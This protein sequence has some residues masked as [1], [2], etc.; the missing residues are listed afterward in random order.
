MKNIA[1]LSILVPV[2]LFNNVCYG[3]IKYKFGLAIQQD[4][5]F[6]TL[7]GNFHNNVQ[8]KKRDPLLS[9]F[10]IGLNYSF[11][12][13]FDVEI[14]MSKLTYAAVSNE[15]KRLVFDPKHNNVN[16][17]FFALAT[18][19]SG[20]ILAEIPGHVFRENPSSCLNIEKSFFTKR[21]ICG[22]NTVDYYDSSYIENQIYF[23]MVA[24]RIKPFK[25]Y[26][27]LIPYLS[28]GL[29]LAFHKSKLYHNSIS[30]NKTNLIKKK[31]SNS[32]IFE[33]GLGSSYK[34]NNRTELDLSLKY[35]DYGAY[36]MANDIKNKI[37]G[38][39]VLF[40]IYN[41]LTLWVIWLKVTN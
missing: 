35:I 16:H 38:V 41:F 5:K 30:Q 20:E 4:V 40:S 12:K 23:A 11:S 21:Q 34:I 37:K 26:K 33:I 6:T 15:Y 24:A 14:A 19:N 32:L 31:N 29:G 8:Y 25:D 2:S 7:S 17:D 10:Y 3:Q 1:I 22:I 28:A 9:N 36:K 39:T 27:K 13:L 18:P